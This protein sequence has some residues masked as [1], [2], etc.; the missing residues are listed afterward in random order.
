MGVEEEEEEEAVGE[1]EE[2]VVVE[3][4]VVGV[5]CEEGAREQGMEG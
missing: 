3:G 4:S 5:V 1:V 2:G